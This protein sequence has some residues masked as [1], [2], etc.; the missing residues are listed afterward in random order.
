MQ[1]LETHAFWSTIH[2]NHIFNQ[3]LRD[4]T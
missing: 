2:V 4:L 3:I 1:L